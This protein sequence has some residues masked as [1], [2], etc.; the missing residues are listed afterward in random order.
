M[1]FE[2]FKIINNKARKKGKNIKI[3]RI[4]NDYVYIDNKKLIFDEFIKKNNM[5]ICT[6]DY[7]KALQIFLKVNFDIDWEWDENKNIVIEAGCNALWHQFVYNEN[8]GIE[9]NGIILERL[10][11]ENYLVQYK[12]FYGNYWTEESNINELA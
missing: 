2:E 1:T 5:N 12:D 8:Y 7:G 4:E 10:D 6:E 3:E 11:E 9:V